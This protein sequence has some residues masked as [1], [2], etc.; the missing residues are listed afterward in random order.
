MAFDVSKAGS[1]VKAIAH[2]LEMDALTPEDKE[3]LELARQ[4]RAYR[5][6]GM[7]VADCAAL[8]GLKESTAQQFMLRGVYK[9]FVHYLDG[10]EKGEDD[11]A[12]DAKVRKAKQ[13]LAHHTDDAVDFIAECFKRNP[14]E[15]RAEKGV[16]VDEGRAQWAAQ[17]V[18]KGTGLLEP[19]RAVR[20]TININI[21]QIAAEQAQVEDDDSRAQA[22]IDVTP[23]PTNA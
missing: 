6:R 13:R 15:E 10:L 16:F 1:A 4:L 22:A 7:K 2:R 18:A 12:A 19:E 8:V 17:Q 20:P 11:K 9:L 21:G 23:P 5:K 14:E 3:R